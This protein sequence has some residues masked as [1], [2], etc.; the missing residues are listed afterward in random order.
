MDFTSLRLGQLPSAAI[1]LTDNFAHEVGSDLRRATV[2]ELAD[3]IAN[4][5]SAIQGAGFRPVNVTDGQ[6]L[7]TTTKKEF[8]LVG[9]GTYFNVNGGAT[10]VLNEELNALV[11][12][13]V[14][15]SIG[16]EIPVNVELAGIVQTIRSGFLTTT[17]SENA[18]FDALALK[19]NIADSAPSPLIKI[20]YPQL[21]VLN[22]TFQIPVG[23]TCRQV[24]V[25]KIQWF[26]AGSNNAYQVD[27]WTQIGD[28]V[29]LKKNA[30]V[31][32]YVVIFYQ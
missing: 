3:F 2:Q 22:D 13:G 19:V 23:S 32:N 25:N 8:I 20:D 21:T 31:N 17:P 26:K 29:I 10:I 24:F 12:N 7:P 16:V 14:F 11:S 18:L 27:T 30:K 1:N 15:W 9:K 28:S 4:Y 5:A 6:T